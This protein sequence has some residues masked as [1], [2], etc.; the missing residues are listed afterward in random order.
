[1]SFAASVVALAE[2][3][4]SALLVEQMGGPLPASLS[5]PIDRAVWLTRPGCGRP[6]HLLGHAPEFADSVLQVLG[7]AE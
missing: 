2:T 4:F 3:D 7:F 6:V 5:A 1:M